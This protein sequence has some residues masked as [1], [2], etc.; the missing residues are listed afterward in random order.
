MLLNAAAR[1]KLAEFSNYSRKSAIIDS[2]ACRW[3]GLS[4]S[5]SGKPRQ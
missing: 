1:E 5:M 4:I 3:Q 2:R